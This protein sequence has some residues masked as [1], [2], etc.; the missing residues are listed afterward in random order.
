MDI[1]MPFIQRTPGT[2]IEQDPKVVLPVFKEAR[3][4]PLKRH[5]QKYLISHKLKNRIN[6]EGFLF[7]T[8]S[9]TRTQL[10]NKTKAI[11]KILEIVDK[12]LII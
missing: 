6:V 10:M 11:E 12:A 5:E 9:E 7:L 8:V 2:P 1:F 4:E 3:L